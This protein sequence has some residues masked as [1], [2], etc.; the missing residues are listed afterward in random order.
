M[1]TLTFLLLAIPLHI[2]GAPGGD[3]ERGKA[4]HHVHLAS[5]DLCKRV[6]GCLKTHH[7]P[8][9]LASDAIAALDAARMAK[10]VVL[11]CA[12][13]Y[14]KHSLRLSAADIAK[15]TR[16]ENEFTAAEVARYPD[17]LIGF[18][19]VDPL[20]DSALPEIRYWAEHGKLVGLKL[21]FAVSEVHMQRPAEREKVAAAVAEAAAHGMPMV[22]HVGAPTFDVADADLFIREVLPRAGESWVQIAHATG[23]GWPIKT[24]RH[25]RVLRVFADH[26][27]KNDPATR[28]L[29]FDLSFV[30]MPEE[31]AAEAAELAKEIRRIGIDRFVF[32]SDF[33]EDTPI[34][35]IENLRRL[36]LTPEEIDKLKRQCAPW[37]C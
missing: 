27:A 8:A 22:I 20:R 19:S 11:S 34:H 32:G 29:L 26:I 1:R 10:G 33:N 9:V 14:G 30:P 24:G 37:A 25:V 13:L 12:Y 36:G 18:L 17:R 15:Y 5:A 16:L 35:Q 2:Q 6:G 23:G 28:H 21:H 4:D 7:P 3:N 31:T